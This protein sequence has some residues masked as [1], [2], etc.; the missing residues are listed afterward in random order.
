MI[1]YPNYENSKIYII[2]PTVKH[3]KNEIYIGSTRFELSKRFHQHKLTYNRWKLGKGFK[4]SSYILFEKY[5]LDNCEIILIE[6]FD[7]GNKTWVA[8]IESLYI[9]SNK[10]VNKNISC[11][12][13][14]SG[15]A[16]KIKPIPEFKIKTEIEILEEE[17]IKAIQ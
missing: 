13:I 2:R 7:G 14:F 1:G 16:V 10:C 17:F 15:E 4:T 6:E 8:Y 12:G 11:K 9:K 5:G 3:E